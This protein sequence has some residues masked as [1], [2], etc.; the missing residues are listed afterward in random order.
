MS[1]WGSIPWGSGP[2]GGVSPDGTTDIN[3]SFERPDPTGAVGG[4][5][6][7]TMVANSQATRVAVFTGG[8]ALDGFESG[9]DNDTY[10]FEF[11]AERFGVVLFAGDW[12]HG[13]SYEDFDLGWCDGWAGTWPG[14]SE[15]WSGGPESFESGWDNDHYAWEYSDATWTQATFTGGG[16]AESFESG[17]HNDTWIDIYDWVASG[18]QVFYD[19]T[20]PVVVPP[21]PPLHSEAEWFYTLYWPDELMS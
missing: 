1:G 9:W 17:W 11:D 10:L 2:W 19:D 14:N 20:P 6:L 8:L 15:E 5:D 12:E 4:A 21:I 3:G 7:W 13:V 18:D 16:G